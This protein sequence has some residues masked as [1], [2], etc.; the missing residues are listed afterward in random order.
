VVASRREFPLRL[1]DNKQLMGLPELS[2]T[3]RSFARGSPSRVSLLTSTILTIIWWFS[4]LILSG[5]PM[6]AVKI[7]LH[8]AA[9]QPQPLTKKCMQHLTKSVER[10]HLSSRRRLQ[11]LLMGPARPIQ[12]QMT[13]GEVRLQKA[14]EATP[15]MND[16]TSKG[17]TGESRRVVRILTIL[18]I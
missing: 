2:R 10:R 12:A 6:P 16:S 11:P 15:T 1:Q 8:K 4:W 13:L 14:P 9:Q 3:S 17:I 5:N 18:S 7:L